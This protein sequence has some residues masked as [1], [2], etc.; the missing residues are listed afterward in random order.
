MNTTYFLNLIA[1]NLFKT[2]TIPAIPEKLFLGLSS[3]EPNMDG[4]NVTEP[5]ASAGYSRIVLSGMSEPTDGEVS[6]LSVIQFNE[7]TSDWGMIPYYVIY[8][9]QERGGGNLLMYAPLERP[10][11]VEAETSLIFKPGKLKFNVQNPA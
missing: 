7:S 5:P 3:T 2:K 1:G 8:D 6:N 11:N 10:R 9:T 4:G